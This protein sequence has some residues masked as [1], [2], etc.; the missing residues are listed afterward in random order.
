MSREPDTVPMTPPTTSASPAQA[1]SGCWRFGAWRLCEADQRLQRGEA[2]PI[3]LDRSAYG[4][5]PYLL[6]HAGEVCT[7]EELLATG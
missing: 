4:V 6:L 7:T 1:T 2:E 5:L 3:E